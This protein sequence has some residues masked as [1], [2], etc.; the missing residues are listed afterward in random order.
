MYDAEQDHSYYIIPYQEKQATT[1]D[2]HVQGACLHGIAQALKG[3]ALRFNAKS[4]SI[5]TGHCDS[6]VIVTMFG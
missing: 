5:N 2:L 4:V 3:N 1:H 6:C